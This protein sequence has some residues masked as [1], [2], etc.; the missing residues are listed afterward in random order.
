MHRYDFN[1][2]R[3]MINIRLRPFSR[4]VRRVQAQ[5]LDLAGDGVAPDAQA[6]RGLHAA[7]VGGHQGR[8]NQARLKEP[9][10]RVPHLGLAAC[11]PFGSEQTNGRFDAAPQFG[12]AVKY[13]MAIQVIDPD[14]VYPPEAAQPGTNGDAARAAAERYRKGT[15]KAVTTESTTQSTSGGSGGSSGSK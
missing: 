2:Y 7:A 3:G 6:L 11:E 12:E 10:E 15:V 5:L 1:S 9:R 8:T 13:D 14:P 4:F